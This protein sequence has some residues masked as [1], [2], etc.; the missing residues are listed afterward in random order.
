MSYLDTARDAARRI[1]GTN[2]E[3]VE[4]STAL[5]SADA[6]TRIA[7][8]FEQLAKGV[9]EGLAA[10]Q[11]SFVRVDEYPTAAEIVDGIL[12]GGGS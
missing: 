10:G 7:D 11:G 1:D 3:I 2:R 5:A 6:L 9:L 12:R 8:A 4:M